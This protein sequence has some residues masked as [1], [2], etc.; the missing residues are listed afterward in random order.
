MLPKMKQLFNLKNYFVSTKNKDNLKIEW[1]DESSRGFQ[2]RKNN[3]AQQLLLLNKKTC[4]Q[5]NH[6]S[7]TKKLALMVDASDKALRSIVP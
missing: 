6:Q 5:T 2:P 7:P 3:Y 1:T 4:Q